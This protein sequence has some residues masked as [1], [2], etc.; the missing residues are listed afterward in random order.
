MANFLINAYKIHTSFRFV[1]IGLL[2]TLFGYVA[3]YCLI[4]AGL[5]YSLAVFLAMATGTIFNFLTYGNWVFYNNNPK[6][7]IKFVIAYALIYSTNLLLLSYVRSWHI[8][9]YMAQGIIT[10][11]LVVLAYL[12]NKYFVFRTQAPK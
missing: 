1:I 12:L 5:H 10:F 4:L 7:I 11:P 8:S 3:F 6:L 2:N 9:I